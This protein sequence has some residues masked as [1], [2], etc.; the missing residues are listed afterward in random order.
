M[1]GAEQLEVRKPEDRLVR[2][3]AGAGAGVAEEQRE[4]LGLEAKAPEGSEDSEEQRE[5]LELEG[6]ESEEQREEL[7]LEAKAAEEQREDPE[8]EAKAAEELEA[9][10]VQRSEATPALFQMLS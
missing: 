5:E 3:V 8:L 9:G 7:E 4:E 1:W 6:K 2:P 10:A